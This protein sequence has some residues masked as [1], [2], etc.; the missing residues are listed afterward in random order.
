MNKVTTNKLDELCY[1]VYIT[2]DFQVDLARTRSRFGIPDPGFA[3][4]KAYDAWYAKSTRKK[5]GDFYNDCTDLV[6]KYHLPPDAQIRLKEYVLFGTSGLR[7]E[8]LDIWVPL[9]E[10][11]VCEV[12]ISPKSADQWTRSGI[13]TARLI[14]SDHATQ[15][16]VLKYVR[17]HWKIIQRVLDTQRGTE[18]KQLVRRVQDRELTEEMLRL[19]KLK[20][21]ELR[22]L[23]PK[24]I[25]DYKEGAIAAIINEHSKEKVT[26]E[27]VKKTVYRRSKIRDVER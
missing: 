9:D 25:Y 21:S 20:L 7:P 8:S 26:A 27:K 3:N 13:P 12:E 14:I 18:K 17:S 11:G 23:A 4:E 15:R 19:N 24:G 6:T 1:R 10:L 2:K 5:D 16:D 22:K